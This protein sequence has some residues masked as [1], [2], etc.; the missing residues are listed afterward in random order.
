MGLNQH[1][2]YDS[3]KYSDQKLL[4]PIVVVP[5]FQKCNVI[6]FCKCIATLLPT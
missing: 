3:N 6:A 1:T 4:S 5:D 2:D